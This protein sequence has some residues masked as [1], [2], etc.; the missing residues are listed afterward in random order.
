MRGVWIA[1]VGGAAAIAG[2]MISD[3]LER[4]NDF[5]N[6]CHL[7]P[8]IRLH[9]KIR[10][11]FDAR[12]PTNLAGVHGRAEK[13]QRASRTSPRCIDCHGGVGF[14]GRLK[15]KALAARDAFVYLTG[16]FDEPD[17]MNFPLGDADCRQCHEDFAWL[18]STAD[19][20]RFHGLSV[21]NADLGVNCVECHT[22]HTGGGEAKLFFLD[23][24]GVRSQCARCHSE[25]R[26]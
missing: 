21:H 7:A 22:V 17:H 6:A 11:D 26:R 16:D 10:E 18:E 5:C 12:E 1:L 3:A 4:N 14:V 23:A 20:S 13:A 9:A 19:E 24:E 15:V 8:G 2:W 25:F